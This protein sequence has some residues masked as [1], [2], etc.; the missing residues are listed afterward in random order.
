MDLHELDMEDE[1]MNGAYDEMGEQAICSECLDY[2]ELKWKS[3]VW[4][5]PIC[6]QELDRLAYFN[7]IGAEPNR[8]LPF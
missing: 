5:C 2:S 6:G 7:Y 4:V 8:G 1:W 3:P